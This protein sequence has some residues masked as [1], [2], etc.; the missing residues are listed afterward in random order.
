MRFQVLTAANMKIR[1]VWDIT[2]CSPVVVD[3]RFRG[4]DCLH[5]QD[6]V[7][8]TRLLEAVRTS[9]TSVCYNETT[10]RNRPENKTIPETSCPDRCVLIFP[11]PPSQCRHGTLLLL[12]LR[13]ETKTGELGR[14]R[15]HCLYTSE[16]SAMVE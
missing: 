2:P 6:D 15:T 14:W 7:F 11:S 5:N 10:R 1:A 3:R 8:I 9:E 12:L 4:A 13:G 16:Y